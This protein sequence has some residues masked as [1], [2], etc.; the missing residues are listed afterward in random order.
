M[1][2]TAEKTN[3]PATVVQQKAQQQSFFRKAEEESFFGGNERPSFFNAPIQS[4][5]A[6]SSPDDPQEKEADAVAETVMRM[7][8]PA[9]TS[10]S[11]S[12]E[13][14]LDKKEEEE[15]KP[16]I[17]TPVFRKISRKEKDKEEVQAKHISTIY[18]MSDESLDSGFSDSYS[19]GGGA[20]ETIS[21]KKSGR[22]HSD[23][24]QRSGR[25]PPRESIPFEQTLSSSKGSGSALPGDT[26]EF[27]ESR[28]N[29]DFSGVRIHTGATAQSMSSNIHAQAFAHGN[30]IYFNE[31]K[32][33][34]Q[35]ESGGTL[36]A[37]ELTHTIQQGASNQKENT[38]DPNKNSTLQQ[39]TADNQQGDNPTNGSQT[40]KNLIPDTNATDPSPPNKYQEAAKGNDIEA[41]DELPATEP[42]NPASAAAE[43][44]EKQVPDKTIPEENTDQKGNNLESPLAP[45][46]TGMSQAFDA[47]GNNTKAGSPDTAGKQPEESGLDKQASAYTANIASSQNSPA[48]PYVDAEVTRINADQLTTVAKI[49]NLAA[50]RKTNIRNQFISAKTSALTFITQTSVLLAASVTVI[51]NMV[52]SR[53]TAFATMLNNFITTISA[54]A[55]GLITQT[56]GSVISFVSGVIASVGSAINGV[57]ST[58][59]GYLN[60]IELPNLPGIG[61]VRTIITNGIVAITSLVGSLL[62]MAQNIISS[63]LT[64]VMNAITNIIQSF[65]TIITTIINAIRSVINTIIQQI[66]NILVVVISKVGSALA[67][68][69]NTVINPIF[70]RAENMVV[71]WIESSRKEAI[72]KANNNRI[73]ALGQLQGFVQNS[74]GNGS[75]GQQTERNKA[76]PP[77]S[78]QVINRI[79]LIGR[80]AIQA[81]KQIVA[82]FD[83]GTA[84]IWAMIWQQ[85]MSSVRQVIAQIRSIISRVRAVIDEAINTII[86]T[87]VTYVQS[88]IATVNRLY[89]LIVQLLGRLYDAFV[90]VINHP[91]DSITQFASGIYSV[92]HNFF[93]NLV[94][95]AISSLTDLVTGNSSATNQPAYLGFVAPAFLAPAPVV[96]EVIVIVVEI[97]VVC[98]GFYIIIIEGEGIIIVIGA[99]IIFIPEEAVVVVIVVVVI[100][101]L[102]LLLLI[103]LLI[104]LLLRTAPK[105]VPVPRPI[106]DPEEPEEPDP[107]MTHETKFNA[108]DGSPKSRRKVGVGEKVTFTGNMPGNWTATGGTPLVQMG[109]NE[110]NW[111]APERLNTITVTLSVGT[112][113]VSEVLEVVEPSHYTAIKIREMAYPAGT[114]GAGMKLDFSFHPKTV[115]FGNVQ[116]KEVSGPATNITGY[117][118][119]QGMPHHHNSGDTFVNISENNQ[120]DNGV[121]DTAAQG[122]YPSPWDTGTFDWIIPNHFKLKTEAGGGKKYHNAT[123]SFRMADATGKTTISKEGENVERTP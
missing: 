96:V 108:P 9:S 51:S 7:P 20:T 10:I 13:E 23:I 119:L 123:Q 49:N 56:I 98:A 71:G 99:I 33:S 4:K 88:V 67:R 114:Q 54:A 110:F 120:L 1:F 97:I 77:V 47:P 121:Q 29:A 31:G 27:M 52:R 90:Q 5:L 92:A 19:D 94:R 48:K 115:S 17:E 45:A 89:Q 46:V 39:P 18:R 40:A 118:L 22:Y 79:S 12:S 21:R 78:P 80:N 59:I 42:R 44:D 11:A 109:G 104:Y 91:I 50:V 69:V 35:T 8:D 66:T 57:S 16:K 81:N 55:I 84:S 24:I 65:A 87:V 36:L 122:G 2:S 111:T 3:Q 76:P 107:S 86:N 95:R 60:G 14:K 61:F 62:S 117:Y 34:P 113:S 102:L 105:P 53:I 64:I 83:R 116:E 38:T 32:F 41:G 68:L 28:F 37:H 85:V 93:S 15:I 100:I 112:K 101:I 6:V 70:S 106:P 63:V 30:D 74:S 58:I 25:S 72:E 43:A 82:E 26:R 103:V 73:A 75:T